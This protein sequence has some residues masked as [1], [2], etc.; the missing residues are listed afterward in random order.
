[1]LYAAPGPFNSP[2]H[3]VLEGVLNILCIGVTF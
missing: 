1:M 2:F 3:V